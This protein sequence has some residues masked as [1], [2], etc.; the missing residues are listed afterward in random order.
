MNIVEYGKHGFVPFPP[1]TKKIRQIAF[2]L[3]LPSNEEDVNMLKTC[4]KK[5]KEDIESQK[6]K[7]EKVASELVFSRIYDTSGQYEEIAR[8]DYFIF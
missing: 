7:G 8:I 3:G 6:K 1:N 2:P 4:I 5:L